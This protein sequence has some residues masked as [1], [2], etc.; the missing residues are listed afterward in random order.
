MVSNTGYPA[1]LSGM[2]YTAGTKELLESGVGTEES[3]GLTG[4]ELPDLTC[5]IAIMP[6]KITTRG[7][8]KGRK[9]LNTRLCRKNCFI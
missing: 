8:P 6:V 2:P 9:V 7:I 1:M 3:T 4:K 5:A